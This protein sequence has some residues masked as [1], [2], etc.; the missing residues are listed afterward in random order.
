MPGDGSPS[1]MLQET[2]SARSES[3]KREEPC[4][5][6]PPVRFAVVRAAIGDERWSAVR[7]ETRDATERFL[8]LVGDLPDPDLMVTAHWSVADTLAH[9]AA[10]A[11]FDVSLVKPGEP[12]P[13]VPDFD[14]LVASTTVATVGRLNAALLRHTADRGMPALAARLCAD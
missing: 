14:A 11:R 6:P 9:L 7:A 2:K 4:R 10:I 8:K 1:N 5:R 3:R 13:P 12:P